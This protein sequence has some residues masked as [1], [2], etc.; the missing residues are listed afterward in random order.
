MLLKRFL[1]YFDILYIFFS[2]YV[3][4]GETGNAFYFLVEG[5]AVALKNMKK[6]KKIKTILKMNDF[7]DKIN[8]NL[9]SNIL[10]YQILCNI[11]FLNF[12]SI[13]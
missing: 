3:L 8:L 6:G 1:T 12:F 11:K 10:H 13:I 5:E 4:K 7:T 9:F 2:F